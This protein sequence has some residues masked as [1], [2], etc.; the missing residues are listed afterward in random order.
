MLLYF[1]LMF[2]ISLAFGYEQAFTETT[3][4]MG[5]ALDETGSR[6]GYQDAITPPKSTRLFVAIWALTLGGVIFGFIKYG[7]LFG[8]LT[9]LGLFLLIIPLN[10]AVIL[11]KKNCEHFRKIIT[12]SM[13]RRHA[14]YVKTGDEIRA[15]AMAEL[16]EKAGIPVNEFVES[17]MR[18]GKPSSNGLTDARK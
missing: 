4:A 12:N 11:P 7:L 17:I 10:K 9:L 6:T 8:I 15:G 18:K 13:I 3:L 2:L 5:R 1:A 14:D 16:L